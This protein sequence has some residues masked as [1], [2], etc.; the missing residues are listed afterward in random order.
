[1]PSCKYP[2]GEDDKR[3]NSEGK[4]REVNGVS[5]GQTYFTTTS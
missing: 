3:R 1:M 2:F 5:P 4:V